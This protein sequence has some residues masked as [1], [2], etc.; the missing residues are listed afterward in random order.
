MLPY[1]LVSRSAEYET[2]LRALLGERLA[3]IP[4]EF[5]T[6]GPD[7]VVSRTN[8][9]PRVALLGPVLNYEETKGLVEAL[10]VKHPD[11]GLIVVRE[12]RS[13]LE[14]WVDE[15]SL[16]AV[17]SPDA[18]DDTTL[19]LLDRLSAWLVANGRAEV[20]DFDAP[21]AL[22]VD[23]MPFVELV[24]ESVG[25]DDIAAVPEAEPEPEPAVPEWEFPPLE[26]GTPS[27]AIAVVA[28][29]GG[30]GKTTIA[31][32]LAT[33]LAEVAPNSVV[34][35]D[36]DL[37]FGDITAALALEPTR[38][39]VDAVADVAADE[40]VLKTTLTHHDDGFFVIAS[41]PSPE[42]GDQV[43]PLALARLIERL[44][45]TFRYVIVDTTP[46]LGEHTLVTLEHVTD[47]VFVTNMGV[48]SLR[49]MRTEFELLTRL[50][51]MPGNRHL[52]VNQTD[53]NSGLTIKDVEH[54]I[55]APVD[56][57]VPKS[58][59]VLL[60]SNRGV[61]LIHDDVRDPAAKAI[62]SIVLRIAPEAF[63]KRSKIQR[64]R[65]TSEPE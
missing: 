39:I 42:L 18:S 21:L 56:V 58:S 19:A 55:G 13:D 15:L 8:G 61:P 2:R 63:P 10:A 51:L 30:Q 6:F 31:I 59:A 28:P 38:T 25:A 1:L 40:I 65:R 50:G 64:R 48:P 60:A 23:D 49:A 45:A 22:E 14:D 52:V 11:L 24:D 3:V 54:I 32:N 36:A 44:R 57:E 7:A 53:K 47:A 5:L 46:G 29:K 9:Q 62:R 17:L 33:G 16:H 27:E 4:G 12:Q 41:A 35:V 20:H 37:Q 43:A 34:L 26:A